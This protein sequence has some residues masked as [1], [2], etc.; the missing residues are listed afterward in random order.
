MEKVKR[1][2]SW[3]IGILFIITF[4]VYAGI[5]YL[6]QNKIDNVIL[7]TIA[8][9]ILALIGLFACWKIIK[10]LKDPDNL[11][12]LPFGPAM[13]IAGLIMLLI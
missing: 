5:F 1:T 3:I 12:Y 4:F 8:S 13:A 6:L 7:L 9:V 2:L 11:T 10:G